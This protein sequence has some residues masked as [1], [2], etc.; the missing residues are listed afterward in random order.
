MALPG[1][2]DLLV[3]L[4]ILALILCAGK[5]S[6]AADRLGRLLERKPAGESPRRADPAAPRKTER[7]P[8]TPR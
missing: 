1:F 2:G 4:F 7:T 3:I 8:A 6:S 5:L